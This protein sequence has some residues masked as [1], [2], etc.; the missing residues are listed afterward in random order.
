MVSFQE[1]LLIKR[2]DLLASNYPTENSFLGRHTHREN[3]LNLS[4]SEP[5]ENTVYFFIL[6]EVAPS[7]PFKLLQEVVPMEKS[8]VSIFPWKIPVGGRG[9]AEGSFLPRTA[10][11]LPTSSFSSEGLSTF[12]HTR[13]STATDA[14]PALVWQTA[15]C[16]VVTKLLGSQGNKLIHLPRPETTPLASPLGKGVTT[17]HTI[18]IPTWR[19]LLWSLTLQLKV[20]YLTA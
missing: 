10:T 15:R 18:K 14:A 7:Q 12:T 20:D 8:H 1:M 19:A 3:R 2:S 13:P 4:F 6:W 17:P 11:M 16:M 5:A 9:G